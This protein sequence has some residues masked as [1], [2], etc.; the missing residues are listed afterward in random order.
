MPNDGPTTNKV[1]HTDDGV[2]YPYDD[3]ED[4]EADGDEWGGVANTG[5][6]FF[7]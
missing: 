4:G 6:S 3:C 7:M 1:E 2:I 5:V